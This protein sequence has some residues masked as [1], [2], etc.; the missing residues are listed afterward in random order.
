MAD[1]QLDT[2]D[3]GER[4]I[5]EPCIGEDYLSAEIRR[6][7]VIASCSY[8]GKTA[9]VISIGELADHVD[10]ALEQHFYRTP[11]EADGID[12]LALKEGGFWERDGSPV[13]YVIAD[14]AGIDDE[15]AEHVREVLAGR[16]RPSVAL[17]RDAAGGDIRAGQHRA[18][19]QVSG[20]EVLR[21]RRSIE[22]RADAVS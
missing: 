13:V 4:T 15:P 1:D 7:G 19:G 2:E 6:D 9:K 3:V 11:D 17:D 16:D 12:L 21:R 8:C 18:A 10:R 5:C 20:G 14:M 22:R